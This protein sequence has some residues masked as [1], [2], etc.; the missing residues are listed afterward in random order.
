M[1]NGRLEVGLDADFLVLEGRDWRELVY[2]L[3]ANPVREVWVRGQ[4]VEP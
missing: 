3:G 4:R 2:N 1:G